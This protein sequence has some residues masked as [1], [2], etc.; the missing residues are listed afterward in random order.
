MRGCRL[1]PYPEEMYGIFAEIKVYLGD[2]SSSIPSSTFASRI[3][4]HIERE[5]ESL[6]A[7]DFL[8]KIQ[9][10]LPKAGMKRVLTI[11][12]NDVNTYFFDWQ[13]QDEWD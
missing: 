5:V 3:E 8:T 12:K 4:R 13:G 1:G 11:S 7:R 2:G 10:A 6:N 9:E